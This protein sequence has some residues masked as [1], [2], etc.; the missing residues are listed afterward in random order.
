[1]ILDTSVINAHSVN[2]ADAGTA[3]HCKQTLYIC[4]CSFMRNISLCLVPESE[5]KTGSSLD[6]AQ[7][8]E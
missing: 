4:I 6:D 2:P 8:S 7:L 3:A 5:N 1:M